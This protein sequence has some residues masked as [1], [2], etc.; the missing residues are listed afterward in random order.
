MPQVL[1]HPSI[2]FDCHSFSEESSYLVSLHD[3]EDDSHSFVNSTN[4]DHNGVLVSPVSDLP[5]RCSFPPNPR[6]TDDAE[7]GS[8][9]EATPTDHTPKDN[10][11]DGELSGQDQTS[12]ANVCLIM[13]RFLGLAELTFSPCAGYCD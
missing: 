3:F 1:R 12:T 8:I 13:W 6:E 9:L 5:Q 2:G 11:N 7:K 4:T 10:L